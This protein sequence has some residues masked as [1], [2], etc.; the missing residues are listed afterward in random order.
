MLI[1]YARVSTDDLT[2]DLLRWSE[3]RGANA[4]LRTRQA[5]QVTAPDFETRST[6]YELEIPSASQHVRA[7]NQVLERAAKA[8][9]SHRTMRSGGSMWRTSIDPGNIQ[10]RKYLR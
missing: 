1:G 5:V 3:R 6:T 9:Q 8:I 2:L 7:R 4:S 10:S